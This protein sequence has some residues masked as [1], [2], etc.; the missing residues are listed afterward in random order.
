MKNKKNLTSVFS[1]FSTGVTIITNGTSKNEYFGC[2]VNS[3]TSLS[4][5]PPQFL[6]CL[7]NDNG[8]LKSFKV[9]SPVN[10]N[11][12]SKAQENLSNKFAGDLIKRWKGVS[13]S[14]AKNKVPFFNKSLGLIESYVEK[15]VK[16]GDHTIV[17]CRV[18]NFEIFNPK[19]P[20]IYYKSKYQSI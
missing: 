20:L 8:N 11:F 18:T 16:S 10:V 19:K 14:L 15:K 7:G 9:Q 12:L 4:L 3:F 13:F 5:D 2:T 17:I 6:F 1:L